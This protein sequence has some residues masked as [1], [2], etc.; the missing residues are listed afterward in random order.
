[1]KYGTEHEADTHWSTQAVAF[2]SWLDTLERTDSLLLEIRHV[3]ETIASQL[4]S[5]SPSAPS[6]PSDPSDPSGLNDATTL[7]EPLRYENHYLWGRFT[8]KIDGLRGDVGFEEGS[9][10][11]AKEK[12][13]NAAVEHDWSEALRRTEFFT[14]SLSVELSTI[15][16]LWCPEY[17]SAT[18]RETIFYDRIADKSRYLNLFDKGEHDKIAKS[19]TQMRLRIAQENRFSASDD[20]LYDSL[21]HLQLLKRDILRDKLVLAARGLQTFRMATSNSAFLSSIALFTI[22]RRASLHSLH[23]RLDAFS[24][25]LTSIEDV[26]NLS[27]ERDPPPSVRRRRDQGIYTT[28]LADNCKFV[29]E[30]I[31]QFLRILAG[32]NDLDLDNLKVHDGIEFI[33]HRYTRAFTSTYRYDHLW[34]ES[35]AGNKPL[36]AGFVQSSF[37][38]PERPDLQPIIVHEIAHLLLKHHYGELSPTAMSRLYDPFGRLLRH[39]A[40]ALE[41]Y[42]ERFV[43][44]DFSPRVRETFLREIA[45]DLIGIAIHRTSYLFADFLELISSGAERIFPPFPN[46]DIAQDARLLVREY[47]TSIRDHRPEWLTRL[48]VVLT[49]SKLLLGRGPRRVDSLETIIHDGIDEVL[50]A[51]R[52]EFARHM[53]GDQRE[54]W[55]TWFEMTNVLTETLERSPFIG[56]AKEWIAKHAELGTARRGELPESRYASPLP[57]KLSE[58][59]LGAW[60]DRLLEKPRLLG[61]YFEQTRPAPE[62]NICYAD[63][64][65]AFCEIYLGVPPVSATGAEPHK[66]LFARLIDIPWQTA[67]L[68]TCDLIGPR[69]SVELPR[70]APDYWIT[71]MHE[72]NWLGRDLYHAALEYVVWFERAPIGRLKAMNRWLVSIDKL[73]SGLIALEPRAWSFPQMS[74][75]RATIKSILG[76]TFDLAPLPLNATKAEVKANETRRANIVRRLRYLGRPKSIDWKNAVVLEK[77]PLGIGSQLICSFEL[78]RED[79]QR[80]ETAS[81]A[82]NRAKLFEHLADTYLGHSLQTIAAKLEELRDWFGNGN[83]PDIVAIFAYA[84]DR[85]TLYPADTSQ[86][87]EEKSYSDMQRHY[88]H[89]ARV[90]AELIRLSHYLEIRPETDAGLV[91]ARHHRGQYGAPK[92]WI[93]V[94]VNYLD[95]PIHRRKCQ[96]STPGEF[97]ERLVPSRSIRVDRI[98]QTYDPSNSQTRRDRF[99]GHR[100]GESIE[101]GPHLFWSP[102]GIDGIRRPPPPPS[103]PKTR[104]RTTRL[105][106]PLLGRFDQFALDIAKHTARTGQYKF[107]TPFFRRQQIGVPFTATAAPPS[108]TNPYGLVTQAKEHA[109]LPRVLQVFDA[110]EKPD[111][112]CLAVPLATISILLV[113]RSARLTFVERLLTEDLVLKSFNDQLCSP[114]SY[115]DPKVDIGLLTDGWGDVFLVLF[116]RFRPPVEAGFDAY[117]ERCLEILHRFDK[118][119]SLRTSIF[120]DALVVRTETSYSPLSV[121]AALLNPGRYRTTLSIRFRS[122]RDGFSL[123]DQF[124]QDLY[125]LFHR[126]WPVIHAHYE[127]ASLDDILIYSRTSGRTDYQITTRTPVER[128]E[129]LAEA[130]YRSISHSADGPGEHRK[131]DQ[132]GVIFEGLRGLI[133]GDGPIR[134][135][136]ESTATAI[137]ELSFPKYPDSLAA[138]GSTRTS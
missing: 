54:D 109:T 53:D 124:E 45:C 31:E 67:L 8:T 118:V 56:S 106:S 120:E 69:A 57:E 15:A 83:D 46:G 55:D 127:R 61:V 28:D 18:R 51:S 13:A 37:W 88:L 84:L 119:I 93:E 49:F 70:I 135:H 9:E 98:S 132:Y 102:W 110:S 42:A 10:N 14:S 113:Q 7:Y 66:Q 75:L 30:E 87:I 112:R 77:R 48:S 97:I 95:V 130:L 36:V 41:R 114:Y 82:H 40:Y 29:A 107:N 34:N 105:Q 19:M 100:P 86:P 39:F 26:L 68:T 6:D 23:S 81:E 50:T 72:F 47:I 3:Q 131:Y 22:V 117:K 122:T 89:Y 27:I 85:H 63:V 129:G 25:I 21:R 64:K 38:M 101:A 1:M 137:A 16:A 133:F 35:L 99:P 94:F 5:V 80:E 58:F 24:D 136:V 11:V 90:L 138:S 92:P 65:D 126:W 2:T 104:Y 20:R 76:D 59:C 52:H 116:G 96:G 78:E 73:L 128:Q 134:H 115:F 108:T 33:I 74:E 43:F 62:N 91:S 111:T 17:P 79:V 71:G 44:F 103:G 121:D 123:A 125:G 12:R 60:L 32:S 4:H